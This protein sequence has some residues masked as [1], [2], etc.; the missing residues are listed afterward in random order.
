MAK[1]E[2]FD[3]LYDYHI[4]GTT[5]DDVE[6]FFNTGLISYR[7]NSIASTLTPLDEEDIE[8]YGLRFIEKRYA[9]TNNYKYCYVVKIPKYYMGWMVHRDGSIEPPIP[10]WI[11]TGELDYN[12][13]KTSILT[14]HL[15]AGVYSLERN[16]VMPNP[17]YNPK[18]DPTGMQYANE[19]IENMQLAYDNKYSEWLKFARA[20]KQFDFAELTRRDNDT[21]FWEAYMEQYESKILEKFVPRSA[22]T[23]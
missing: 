14:P 10:M 19:Q 23:K 20:R 2:E 17:N 4:H 9:E 8:R 11:P 7:E 3:K 15:I 16:Q 18:Y 5:S 22:R 1:F 13:R 12:G 21:N 6:S